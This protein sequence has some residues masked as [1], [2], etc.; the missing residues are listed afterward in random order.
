MTREKGRKKKDDGKV[1]PLFK[2]PPR[3]PAQT[4]AE[5]QVDS[6]A[7]LLLQ[8]EQHF[9]QTFAQYKVSADDQNTLLV[10]MVVKLVKSGK[11]KIED[12]LF[13]AAGANVIYTSERDE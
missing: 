4:R 1:V 12:V 6:D 3:V 2:K 11:V 8:I 10:C 9:L 7:Q 13:A 5:D